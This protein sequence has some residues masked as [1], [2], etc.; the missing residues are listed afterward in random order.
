VNRDRSIAALRGQQEPWDLIVIGGGATGCGI[1]WDAA[2]RGYRVLLL[3]QYDFGKGTSSRSTR[4]IHGGVR[5]LAQGNIALVREALSERRTLLELA[6]DFVR[7]LPIIMPAA[8]LAERLWYGTGLK[9]Y[10]LLA[11]AQP[12]P[13]SSLLGAEATAK[14]LPELLPERN[15][16]SVLYYDAQFDDNRL[17]MAVCRRASQL[18]AVLLNHMPVTKAGADF[19]EA[20]CAFTGE[21]FRAQ[22]RVVIN[23]AGV[24]ADE[25]RRLADPQVKPLLR[26]SRGAH[27]VFPRRFLPGQ[28]AL[29]IPKTPDGRVMF[30]IPWKGHVLAGTTD[31]ATRET[32]LDPAA[33]AIDCQQILGS[34]QQYLRQPPTLQDAL[35]AF[36]GLRPLVDAG[37]A[38]SAALS[39]EHTL[40]WEQSGILTIT[41]GKWTTF[42]RM[43]MECVEK[44]VPR[45]GLPLRPTQTLAQPL[46]EERPVLAD[47][48]QRWR[49]SMENEMAGTIDDLLA[50][51]DSL[52]F[53]DA[54]AARAMAPQAGR[55]LGEDPAAFL[56]QSRYYVP[57]G[58][59]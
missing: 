26:P 9:L 51:R 28:H 58:G 48:E 53:E 27:L 46:R 35:T 7:P 10:D 19:V 18:G 21:E 11:G 30:F 36:A 23:A 3:E 43:A 20:H 50:R 45:A 52:L 25:V 37:N 59:D 31:T 2:G 5:Y 14:L 34:L 38:V 15:G 47:A 12:M 29:I 13:T 8:S 40:Q 4:L 17:L 39:R 54:R 33:E 57:G 22:G 49:W 56:E 44:A 42:R 1:A 6:S 55:L 24:F 41:G 16:G 32:A